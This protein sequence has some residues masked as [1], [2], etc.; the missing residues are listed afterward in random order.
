ML[1]ADD[2]AQVA[3]IAALLESRVDELA[4]RVVD[5]IRASVDFYRDN[6]IVSDDELLRVA[7]DNLQLVFRAL[8]DQTAF[9]TSVSADAGRRRARAGVPLTAV[10]EAYRVASHHCWVA[11]IDFV[12]D[13]PEIA[14]A[15]V[16]TATSKM[17]QAQDS[18]TDAMTSAYHEEATHLV[19]ENATEQAALTE[20]LLEGRP[21]GDYSLW[22][23]AR[24]LRIP[25]HGPY[26]VITA[27]PPHV[28]RQ[29]LPGAQAMLRSID[30]HSAWRLLPDVQLGIAHIPSTDA[31]VRVVDLLRRVET[32]A[33]GVSPL[34]DDLA[35]T[36]KST[37]YARVAMSSRSGDGW[38]SV[39]EDSVLAVAAVSAPDVTRKLAEITLGSFGDLPQ[40]EKKSLLQTFSAWLAHDGSIPETATAL[41]CHP[42]TV[43][44]RLRRI[45][46]RTGRSLSTPL[47]LAELCLAFEV[48]KTLPQ[49][50]ES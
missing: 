14:P 26:L 15:P 38:V 44:N 32:T 18:Y 7:T 43:R 10:M 31:F 40:E 21:L 41:F 50:N 16:L 2:D 42:N 36:A 24:L 46:E 45:E 47:E 49:R 3:A 27:E 25:A 48:V 5:S 19:V 13:H 17:W 30:V 20:A 9:D 35:D 22:D 23:V 34:F 33:V 39:F 11:M 8:R 37:R 6:D 28:G 12:G 29:A 1:A 4:H